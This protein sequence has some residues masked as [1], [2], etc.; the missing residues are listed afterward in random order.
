MEFKKKL[1]ARLAYHEMGGLLKKIPVCKEKTEWCGAV[2]VLF[3]FLEI[4]F[5]DNFVIC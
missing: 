2:P 3:E 1:L 5:R 4:L